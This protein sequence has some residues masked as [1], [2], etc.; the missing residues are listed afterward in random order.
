MPKFIQILAFMLPAVVFGQDSVQRFTPVE[1]AIEI[2]TSQLRLPDRVPAPL[3]ARPCPECPSR[4]LQLTTA[5]RFLIGKETVTWPAF[6]RYV[7]QNQ[8]TL[9]IFYDKAFGVTRLVAFSRP[10]TR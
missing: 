8:P 1:Q 10:T 6:S 3:L 5:T 9:G 7:Q 2:A 4:S